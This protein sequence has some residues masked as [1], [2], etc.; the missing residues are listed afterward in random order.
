MGCIGSI[1]GFL[2]TP[3]AA[4]AG[5]VAGNIIRVGLLAGPEEA[6]RTE[7]GE[8]VVTG[9]VTNAVLA[10]LAGWMAGTTVGAFVGGALLSMIIG[11]RFDRR[12]LPRVA[13]QPSPG[14]DDEIQGMLSSA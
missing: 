11:D 5:T 3:V 4:L 2:L 6:Q 9:V 7:S 10:T 8:L 1:L 12:L 13:E 14:E